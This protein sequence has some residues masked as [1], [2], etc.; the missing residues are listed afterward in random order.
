MILTVQVAQNGGWTESTCVDAAVILA[1]SGESPVPLLLCGLTQHCF[2]W[3]MG[4]HN[5]EMK[6]LE[7]FLNILTTQILYI[8]SDEGSADKSIS[9][10][11]SLTWNFLRITVLSSWA[12]GQSTTSLVLK[13]GIRD[14]Q[15]SVWGGTRVSQ[16]HNAPQ[17]VVSL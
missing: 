1:W 15:G 11:G 14:P 5:K 2:R 17:C 8:F 9:I 13:V 12:P 4:K 6:C 3:A 10:C 7:Y 16:A